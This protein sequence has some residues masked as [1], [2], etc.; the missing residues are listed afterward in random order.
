MAV[1]ARAEPVLAGTAHGRLLRL[2]QPLSFWGGVDAA[3][4]IITDA[5]SDARGL[6]IAGR[7]LCIPATR[8]SSSSSAV[9][10][11]LLYR[12]NAPAAI[13]LGEID[14]IL[15]LGI[16]VAREMGWPTIPLATLPATAIA[17]LPQD[18]DVSL[19]DDGHI[20]G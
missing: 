17:A 9:L 1:I 19:A 16:I 11:E 8:G 4:G 3:T 7:L 20:T 14:A 15:G 10:L 2:D 18:L 12:G 13:V 6:S 5:Q